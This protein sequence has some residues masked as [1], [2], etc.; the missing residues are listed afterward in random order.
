MKAA[1]QRTT[2]KNVT[3]HQVLDHR[4]EADRN[5]LARQAPAIRK[6]ERSERRLLLKESH[7]RK[8]N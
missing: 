3:A 6:G 5:L 8:V 1:E 4:V 2:E 7:R